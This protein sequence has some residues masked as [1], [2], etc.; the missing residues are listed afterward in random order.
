MAFKCIDCDC[1]EDIKNDP[2]T[3]C[4]KRSYEYRFSD[5]GQDVWLLHNYNITL[6]EYRRMYAKQNKK[7]FI[8]PELLDITFGQR[9]QSKNGACVDHCHETLK[10]RGILCKGCNTMVGAFEK[11]KKLG[12][13]E[14][15]KE[16][17][18]GLGNV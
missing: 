1:P 11:A 3:D 7:C 15:I 16:Y 14:K 9:A 12:L 17:I 2:Y 5:R 13:V 18:D 6:K 10:V 4:K 8:C